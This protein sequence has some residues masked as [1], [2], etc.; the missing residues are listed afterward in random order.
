MP[1][2]GFSRRTLLV[3]LLIGLGIIGVV[4]LIL[5]Y[6][7]PAPPSK[8]TMATA[9]KGASFDWFGQRYREHFAKA[10]VAMNL[11]ETDGALEN[12]AFLQDPNSGVQIGF[13]TGGVSNASL[14]SGL[15]SLGT[16][17]YLPIWIFYSSGEPIDRLV[18]LRG[19]RIAVGP[20]GSGTRH[21]AEAILGKGGVSAETA[22][23][24]PLAGSAAAQALFDGKL[25]AA[26]ILGAPDASAV[27][28]LLRAPNVRLMNFPTAEAFTRIFPNLVRLVLPQGVVDVE[29]N[30]PP[31]DISLIATTSSVLVRSDLHPAIVSLLLTTMVDVHSKPGIF[32][33]AGEFPK[34]TDPDFPVAAAAIEFYKNGPSYLQRHLPLWMTV[35]AQRAIAVLVTAIA[36]GLPAFHYLPLLYQWIMRR[37][38]L[39]WY[40]EL[41]SLEISID[42][43][44]S[45]GDLTPQQAELDRIERA[46]SQIR[47]PLAFA[48][49]IY[50]LR[51]HI[52]IVR[53]RFAP[54]PNGAE[55]AIA[56]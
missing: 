42:S 53:R 30:I 52:H 15:L 51:G 46:V 28:S 19:K 48:D 6:F 37:R 41:K 47:F 29:A 25:D 22:T 49:Q 1:F 40:G 44:A 4:S 10:N 50:D 45:S 34:P 9:F 43:K 54:Q 55:R 56:E 31:N 16:V 32:Q 7:L 8:V 11:R 12:L 18:Q 27:Q 35:H 26:L 20:V 24:V 33:R 3:G 38:L 39:Y 13:V 21:T 2:L 17:D 23:L 14:S 36:I 5:S